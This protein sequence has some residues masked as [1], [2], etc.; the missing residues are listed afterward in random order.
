MFSGFVAAIRRHW[1]TK[2]CRRRTPS[3]LRQTISTCWFQ[4]NSSYASGGRGASTIAVVQW[5]VTPRVRCTRSGRQCP[6]TDWPLVNQP[7]TIWLLRRL[8]V[9]LLLLLLWV[10][11]L[12]SAGSD[13]GE[14]GSAW[15]PKGASCRLQPLRLQSLSP[16]P[17]RVAIVKL[18]GQVHC[19]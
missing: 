16:A 15:Q 17:G 12:A 19:F 2:Y 1:L 7:S 5:S 11:F 4:G 14:S 10:L 9:L 8:V 13:T 6:G 18:R 3:R